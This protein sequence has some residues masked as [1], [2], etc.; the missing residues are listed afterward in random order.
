M[1]KNNTKIEDKLEAVENFWAWK[2]RVL[3]ILEEHDLEDYV[4]E[5]VANPEGDE[6]KASI[7]RTSSKPIALFASPS[8]TI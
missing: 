2:Y 6:D 4:K 7:R 8:K 3:L 1:M 5:E